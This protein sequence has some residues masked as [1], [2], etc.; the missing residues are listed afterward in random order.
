MEIQMYRLIEANERSEAIDK[1]YQ[2]YVALMC[3]IQALL[4]CIEVI[5]V[6]SLYLG[7]IATR[8]LLYRHKG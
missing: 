8:R 6:I 3:C 2:A 7:V 5:L 1:L 4:P